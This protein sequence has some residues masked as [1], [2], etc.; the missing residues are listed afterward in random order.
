VNKNEIVKVKRQENYSGEMKIS[1]LVLESA[2]VLGL[3]LG[4]GCATRRNVRIQDPAYTPPAAARE[5]AAP[6][7]TPRQPPSAK[8]AV[9]DPPSTAPV[10]VTEA[11]PPPHVEVVRLSP[12]PEYVWMPG[13]W[14][15][16]NHWTWMNG[17]WAVKPHPNA[18][19][20]PG[21]WV[22]RETGWIWV[23]GYWR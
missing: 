23:H 22:R 19:W 13:Y 15:W 8:P 7:S 10:F 4:P 12:G 18:A 6:D 17:H 3:C 20:L 2:L 9:I 5:P 14:E 1:I 21:R 16:K 11:P